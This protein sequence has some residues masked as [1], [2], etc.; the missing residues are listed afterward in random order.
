M[1]LAHRI[2]IRPSG[3]RI[4]A[5]T[6]DSILEAALR[7]GCN[8]SHRCSNGTCGD[9]RVRIVSG[10]IEQLQHH[11]FR[12][13]QAE[14]EAGMVLSCCSRVLSDTVVEVHEIG[15]AHEVPEQQIVARV[16]RLEPL[17]GGVTLLRVRTPRSQTL[18]F[19][20]GHS[21]RRTLILEP[22]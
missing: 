20:A 22:L 7:A 3:R 17:S 21:P 10:K 5:Q 1:P 19:L 13:P 6:N 12:I 15:S 2:E 16:A 4:E 8:L 11:D 18:Q 14:K 9:C